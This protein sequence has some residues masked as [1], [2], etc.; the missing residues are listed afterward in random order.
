M[1]LC[2]FEIIKNIPFRPRVMYRCKL[3]KPTYTELWRM[4]GKADYVA[5]VI[6]QVAGDPIQG[7]HSQAL[8]IL[9]IYIHEAMNYHRL[10]FLIQSTIYKLYLK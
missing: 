6:N 3:I 2:Q 9:Y 5:R 10:V 1:K 7:M 4:Y 8:T